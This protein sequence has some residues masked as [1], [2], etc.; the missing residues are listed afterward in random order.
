M[1]NQDFS[2]QVVV[3]TGAS[4]DVGAATAEELARRSASVVL[5]ARRAVR[6]DETPRPSRR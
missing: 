1:S 2:G 5:A 3:V 4:A 6:L